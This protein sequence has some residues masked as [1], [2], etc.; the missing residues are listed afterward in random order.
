MEGQ[1]RQ[2]TDAGSYQFDGSA[3][4]PRDRDA[5][6]TV[7]GGNEPRG[8]IF[9]KG[10]SSLTPQASWGFDV[11]RAS[12]DTYLRR[13]GFGNQETLVSRVFGEYVQNRDYAQLQGMAFQGLELDADPDRVPMILPALDATVT[14]APLW[15]GSRAR[16]ETNSYL[17]TRDVGAESRRLSVTTGWNVP[18]VTP[19]GHVLTADASLRTDYYDVSNAMLPGGG[20]FDGDVARAIPRL[21]VGWRYPMIRR[22]RDASLIVEPNI[23]FI[24][25][26]NGNNPEAIPNEDS[27]V[28][29]FSD[30]NLFAYDRFA[31]ADR[32]ENGSRIVY[33]MRGQWEFGPARNL[34][35]GVLDRIA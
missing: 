25:A 32:V 24:A 17:L 16:L 35:I 8:H 4:Y 28:P 19:G 1:Y 11:N 6:G 3:T 27:L 20:E 9:A 34:N 30:M 29:E 31:G 33:G 2:R 14:S 22:V 13:Y 23:E 7:S 5:A 12:D 18:H 15:H 21:A 26:S 10:G